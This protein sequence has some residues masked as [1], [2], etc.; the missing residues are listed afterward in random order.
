MWPW[1]AAQFDESPWSDPGDVE[2]VTGMVLGAIGVWAPFLVAVMISVAAVRAYW[3][4][5]HAGTGLMLA[6][7]SLFWIGLVVYY[8][9]HPYLILAPRTVLMSS[10]FILTPMVPLI[11]FAAGLLRLAWTLKRRGPER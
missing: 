9:A 3:V 4:S 2:I 11:V 6:G 1:L 5:R 7:V 10:L 8:F